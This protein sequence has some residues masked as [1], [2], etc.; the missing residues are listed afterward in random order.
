[1]KKTNK[2]LVIASAMASIA[3]C[4][5]LIA[6]STYALFTSDSSVNIAV[7]SAKVDVSASIGDVVATG[8]NGKAMVEVKVVGNSIELNNIAPG[9]KVNFN[10]TVENKSTIDV[11]Y[12]TKI[13]CTEGEVLM[14]ALVFNVGEEDYSGLVSYVSTWSAWDK[15]GSYVIPVEIEL[16]EEVTEYQGLSCKVTYAVE[17]IQGNGTVVDESELIKNAKFNVKN[18]TEFKLAMRNVADNGVINLTD[19]ITLTSG[20]STI[21]KN[22]TLNGNDHTI[23]LNMGL[24][25]QAIVFGAEGI[26]SAGNV[27]VKDLTVE[28]TAYSGLWVSHYANDKAGIN[29]LFENVT[30]KGQYGY[31]AVLFTNNTGATLKNCHIENNL[32]DSQASYYQYG[33]GTMGI[34]SS[35]Y[36]AGPITLDNTTVNTW[37]INNASLKGPKAIIENNS[38]VH[39]LMVEITDTDSATYTVDEDSS[40]DY[41]LHC[42]ENGYLPKVQNGESAGAY[43]VY[44]ADYLAALATN[45]NNGINYAGKTVILA[46]DIDLENA[47][48]TPIGG[49]TVCGY[50]EKNGEPIYYGFSGVFDGNE[51]TVSNLNVNS[52]TFAGLFGYILNSGNSSAAIKNLTVNNAQVSGDSEVGVIVG[53]GYQGRVENCHVTG[54]INVSGSWHV[55]G[56]MGYGYAAVNNCSV[57]CEEGSSVVGVWTD[58][59]NREGDAVGGLIGYAPEVSTEY[60]NL[61]AKGVNVEGTRKVGGLIGQVGTYTRLISNVTV[62]NVTVSINASWGYINDNEG[63][64]FVGGVLGEATSGTKVTVTGKASNIK[65]EGVEEASTGAVAGGK[66]TSASV[67][68][69]V[70]G[71]T[72]ENIT[73]KV[74]V[75]LSSSDD[76]G[77]ALANLQEGDTLILGE[78]TYVL[79]ANQALINTD[80][81]TIKGAGEGK[82]IIVCN[83][84]GVS[85][86][87]AFL[88]SAD[89][90]TVRDL[91]IKTEYAGYDA[92]KVTYVGDGNSKS[93][94]I[95]NVTIKNVTVESKNGH[96]V[97]LHGVVG[98]TIDN[99]TVAEKKKCG[100]SVSRATDVVFTNCTVEKIGWGYDIGCQYSSDNSE[101]GYEFPSVIIIGEGNN[102][103]NGIIYSDRTSA[104]T[105]G[106]DEI[107]FN[108]SEWEF[109]ENA[110]GSWYLTK[111]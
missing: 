90:V 102:F 18:A 105:G 62:E 3:V 91:T 93:A 23:T 29:S 108:A 77:A 104:A 61:T 103:K 32:P 14:S 25:D 12:R 22:V 56:L 101:Q 26:Y 75:V 8:L 95:K 72:V 66:R 89:N 68:I 110:S 76:L 70:A 71:V 67:V 52:E 2:T 10:I 100:F 92:L 40:V 96:G 78:G 79:T 38:V 17:A 109:H 107:E 20:V 7:T 31:A 37:F 15:A 36:L 60:T 44:S 87:A 86:Q 11:Q 53:D 74:S 84:A 94:D 106:V 43:V 111:K 55:G 58:K 34:F 6:G 45:V 88:I 42:E 49:V 9:D 81:V 4:A 97:N 73:V 69:D 28:G 19:D 13:A 80:G 83:E 16:P 57:I 59:N 35:N 41:Y 27:T 50:N 21:A 98:A 30:V 54:L 39:C 85:G 24:N 46:N 33:I 82:T 1:M 63:K 5:S 99:V 48:W 65:V 47:A 51:H 64:L